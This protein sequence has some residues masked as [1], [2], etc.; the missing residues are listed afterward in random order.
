MRSSLVDAL[1]EAF[2]CEE[3]I[4]LELFGR[5]LVGLTD[6]TTTGRNSREVTIEDAYSALGIGEDVD[7]RQHRLTYPYPFF[8]SRRAFCKT[9]VRQIESTTQKVVFLAGDPGSGK[10]STISYL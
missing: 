8:E 7:E 2:S 5:L 1:A 10:T 6:W 9:V 4:A 3:G